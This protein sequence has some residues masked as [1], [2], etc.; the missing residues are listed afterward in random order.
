MSKVAKKVE[1]KIEGNTKSFDTVIVK[2]S[3][4]LKNFNKRAK[5][6]QAGANGISTGFKNA[7]NSSAILLGPLNGVSGR[8]SSLASAFGHL[9]PLMVAS[10]LAVSSLA[11]LMGKAVNAASDYEVAMARLDGVIKATGSAAG[12]TA[13]EFDAMAKALGRD[14]LAS[15]QGVREAIA[16][17]ATFKTVAGDTFERTLKISQD[18]AD[19]MGTNITS[20]AMRMGRA[21]ESPTSGLTSLTRAGITFTEAEKD[22]IKALEE[23]GD[24]LEAQERV[25]LKVEGQV[26]GVAEVMGKTLAGS[27]DTAG[28][29]FITMLE[30]LGKTSGAVELTKK[31]FEGLIFTFDW[32]AETLTTSMPEATARVAELETAML[33]LNAQQ[34]KM[35]LPGIKGYDWLPYD[36]ATATA[37]QRELHTLNRLI[38]KHNVEQEAARQGKLDAEE[39]AAK[40]QEERA[41]TAAKKIA[42]KTLVY[43]ERLQKDLLKLR[44]TTFAAGSGRGSKLAEENARFVS[45]KR[46]ADVEHA[47]RVEKGEVAAETEDLYDRKIEALIYE[48]HARK[49]AI[50]EKFDQKDLEALNKKGAD[51]LAAE[52]KWA[53]KR[54]QAQQDVVSADPARKA[55][56]EDL[57]YTRQ[58]ERFE[59]E[60]QA[61]R[62]KI[63]TSETLEREWHLRREAMLQ[64]HEERKRQIKL[65]GL[66]DLVAEE[67]ARQK[68]I[69]KAQM[70]ELA[71]AQKAVADRN[72]V[73][74]AGATA[75]QAGLRAV[76]DLMADGSREQRVAVALA[77]SVALAKAMFSLQV[78]I[79]KANEGTW[80][81]KGAHI[82]NASAIGLGAIANIRNTN[83]AHGGMTDVPKESTYLL[84]KGERVLSPGQ[85]KDLL[86]FMRTGGGGG[87]NV[88]NYAGADVQVDRSNGM[89]E[90]VINAA[91][92][93]V[94]NEFSQGSRRT[95]AFERGYGITRR[96][97]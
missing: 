42:E 79:S 39:A 60:I 88:H 1:V 23:S 20:E 82:A 51:L 66:A 40:S 71:K 89:L 75:A 55:E 44:Q 50:N 46:L 49:R 81:E 2:S 27:I 28:E 97:R 94:F 5:A 6:A 91:R 47:A 54:R 7:A 58:Q 53:D 69:D 90:V 35:R 17:L 62:E 32:W 64:E 80:W 59:A 18:L 15:T 31:S 8:L 29:S 70:L 77:K 48:H 63:G 61:E 30:A 24:L 83:I 41:V 68:A 4:E 92:D 14:T 76:G 85:N 16:V 56:A 9:N 45:L 57:R 52:R 84:D 13:A 10:G 19:T 93:S 74:M 96:G 37:V 34:V 65:E 87:V 26:E 38:L 95:A 86:E 12:F 72:R 36:P 78:A 33:K 3:E 11:A 25:L 22:I 73:I 67:E 43:E 21:L